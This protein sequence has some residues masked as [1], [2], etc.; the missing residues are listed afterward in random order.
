MVTP[1][2][3]GRENGNCF[4]SVEVQTF[5]MESLELCFITMRLH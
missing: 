1:E 2:A 5:K 4:M 3:V